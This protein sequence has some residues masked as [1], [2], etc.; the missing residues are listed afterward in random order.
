MPATENTDIIIVGGG[1]LGLLTARRLAQDGQHVALVDPSGRAGQASW[2]GAGLLT[3]VPPWEAPVEIQRLARAS[4][5]IYPE[6]C[7]ALHAA[8][9][10]DPELDRQDVIW[11]DPDTSAESNTLAGYGAHWVEPAEAA[12]RAPGSRACERALLMEGALTVRNPRLLRA[13]RADLV[14]RGVDLIDAV[15]ERIEAQ[16]AGWRVVL[17]GGVELRAAR[18][19][20]AAG[21]WSAELLRPL[22]C[23]LPVRPMRGQILLYQQS[24]PVALPVLL[25]GEHY[26]VARRDGHLLIGSTVEDAGFEPVTTDAAL[27][28]LRQVFRRLLPGLQAAEVGAWAGLRPGSPDGIPFIG[29]VPG[30]SGLF[31]CAGHFRLGLTLAPASADLICD[32][33]LGADGSPE[34]AL[35]SVA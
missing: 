22:G 3:P 19:L 35:P 7:E 26:L 25:D 8:T 11:L 2:A 16:V 4:A 29:E 31:V 1:I 14:Q 21:A 18:V 9:G 10:I 15:A 5:S 28:E 20:V 23:Q 32:L 12:H 27:D 24:A 30:H 33:I 34:F 6:L 13:A 17:R